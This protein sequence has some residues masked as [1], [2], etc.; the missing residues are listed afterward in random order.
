MPHTDEASL[1]AAADDWGH[2]VHHRPRAVARPA[3]EDEVVAVLA[4]AERRGLPFAVRG[5]GHSTTGASQC[6][7]GLVVETGGVCAV[8]HLGAD[9]V[10]VG[11]GIR[12]SELLRAT[13]PHGL[14]PPVLTDYLELSVGGTL[15]VGGIGGA[16]HRHGLQTDNVLSL[17][18]RTPD[19]EVRDCSAEQDA[20]LF[21]AVRAGHG[22]HG[23]ILRATLRLVP[24]PRRVRHVQHAYTDLAEFL[25]DQR[26]LVA[27]GEYDHVEGMA[28]PSEGGTG[29]QYLL[30]TAVR[31]PE[32]EDYFEFLNAM[33]P[34]EARL[35]ATGAWSHPHP[36][37]NTF[38]P[39]SAAD[40]VITETM[41][42]LS[43]AD[44]GAAD[45]GLVLLY[46]FPTSAVGTPGLRLPAEPVAFLFALLRTAPPADPAALERMIS[47]NRR[48]RQRVLAA[49]GTPYLEP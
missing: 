18:V 13:L 16:T 19:G 32:G 49:G 9:S 24:A 27:S 36:W 41:A 7:G 39:G 48:L 8:H 28:V 20:E 34:Q 1:R 44:V 43:P 25:A 40:S 3:T 14:A 47:G 29:W 35:R 31:A 37:T 42:P 6:E 2:L 4:D 11:A 15:S 22:R 23:V 46:P 26:E 33:A 30:D 21:D 10:T 12:W 17:R 5:Q 38:L 45:G